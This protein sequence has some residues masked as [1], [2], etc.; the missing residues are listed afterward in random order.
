MSWEKYFRKVVKNDIPQ[1]VRLDERGQPPA[2]YGASRVAQRGLDELIGLCKGILADGRICPE[3]FKLL[4]SWLNLNTGVHDAWPANILL[5][6][7]DA[8]LEDDKIDPAELAELAGTLRA[9]LGGTPVYGYRGGMATRLPLD[10]PAPEVVFA[11]KSFVFTG[12]FVYGTRNTC[13]RQTEIRKGRVATT[14]TR[15]LD[16]LVIGAIGSRDWAH[17][18][19]GR[20]IEK[21]VEVRRLGSRVAIIAEEHWTTY[22]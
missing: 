20:K 7:L 1:P 12:T 18:T 14:V 8:I 3:E 9:M 5:A 21:A 16:Y 2:A 11:H 6:R 17:S 4:V 19:H 22:L 13:H 15:E 10:H